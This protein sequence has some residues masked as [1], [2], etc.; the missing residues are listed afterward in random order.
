MR[1]HYRLGHL[2]FKLIKEMSDVVLLTKNLSKAP[3]PKCA[4]CMFFETKK[5][6]WRTKGKKT[7]GQV[8]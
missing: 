8:G 6:P 2:S 3:I 5:K 7:G 4:V 1:W